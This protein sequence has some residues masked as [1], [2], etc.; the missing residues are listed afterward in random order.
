MK[1]RT[2]TYLVSGALLTMAATSCK[3]GD[4][5]NVEEERARL[6]SLFANEAFTDSLYNVIGEEME[7]AY[8]A[9][10][11][12][13][14]S[15]LLY[16]AIDKGIEPESYREHLIAKMAEE[17][18]SQF[19]GSDMKTEL[20]KMLS[21]VK[22]D[23][24]RARIQK[25]YDAFE[26]R[27][28]GL[29]PGKPAPQLTFTDMD[30]NEASLSDLAG[31]AL[32]IDIWATWCGPCKE[33]IPFMHKLQAHFANDERISI[34]SISC[35]EDQEAWTKFVND[36]GS[37]MDWNQYLITK[38]GQK[39]LSDDYAVYGIPRFMMIDTKGNFISSDAPRPSEPN[40]IEWIEGNLK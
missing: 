22:D 9:D 19:T 4:G 32:F 38:E 8:Q 16:G 39:T 40:I 35:D 24:L 20:D 2:L 12:K 37:E 29:Q 6:D 33:E 27:F 21:R 11:N 14:Y 10:S 31:K 36:K 5:Q 23:T 17:W 3:Q 7:K 18:L 15:D 13:E 34:V 28:G 26:A 1:K 30:G 25:T